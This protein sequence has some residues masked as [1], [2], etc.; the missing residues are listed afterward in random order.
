M[1]LAV[2][3]SFAVGKHFAQCASRQRMRHAS[4]RLAHST[5]APGKFAEPMP[6]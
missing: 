3:I 4:A 6:A 5:L 2:S 1:Q